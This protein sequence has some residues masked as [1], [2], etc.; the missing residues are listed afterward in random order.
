MYAVIQTGG[1]QYRVRPGDLLVVE[2]LDGEP[3]QEVAF[4]RVLMLGGEGGQAMVGAPVVSNRVCVLLAAAP[5]AIA[6]SKACCASPAWKAR[7]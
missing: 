4:D 5:K 6:S 2:K 1:K 3:G 7:E